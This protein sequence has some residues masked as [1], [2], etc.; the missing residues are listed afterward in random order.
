[1]NTPYT[2]LSCLTFIEHKSAV[3]WLEKLQIIKITFIQY[4]MH[5]L[6]FYENVNKT[7]K[8]NEDNSHV[9]TPLGYLH[10]TNVYNEY[11]IYVT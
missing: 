6:F 7:K 1:M 9:S 4:K 3:Q 8:R 5:L 2:E 10:F 11:V